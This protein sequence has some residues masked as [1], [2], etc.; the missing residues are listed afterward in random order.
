M[1]EEKVARLIRRFAVAARAHHGALEA[2]DEIEANAHARVIAGLFASIVAAGDEGREALLLLVASDEP[3]V[4]GM[5]A[6]YSLRYRPEVC[7][8]VLRRLAAGEGLLAF[9]AAAALSRWEE[10]AWEL[11]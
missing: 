5:A 4:A 2:L 1:A 11:P 10:G 8:A 6:V 7:L 9:R 3:E